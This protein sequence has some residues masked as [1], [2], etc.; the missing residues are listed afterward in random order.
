VCRSKN[1]AN[2]SGKTNCEPH[3]FLS[4]RGY[5]CGQSIETSYNRSDKRVEPLLG[6]R[7]QEISASKLDI[8]T[9]KYERVSNFEC[10][11]AA[12]LTLILH[13]NESSQRRVEHRT[14]VSI[15]RNSEERKVI[16]C[17]V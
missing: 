17:V 5:N 2:I 7:R 4:S 11:G 10:D 3:T 15:R 14:E 6:C 8:D 9:H 1:A 16:R 12:H 13:K